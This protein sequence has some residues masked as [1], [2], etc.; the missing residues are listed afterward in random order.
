MQVLLKFPAE[1]VSNLSA[2][3]YLPLVTRLANETS[4]KART[5]AAATLKLLHKQLQ[6]P[7]ND[8]LAGYS[9]QW[10]VSNSSQ[11]Q[12]LLRVAA[13][14][15]LGLL[16]E[17][18]GARF[19]QRRLTS[20][21]V[22]QLVDLLTAAAAEAEDALAAMVL[23]DQQQQQQGLPEDAN[24]A[25]FSSNGGVPRWQEVYHILLMLEKAIQGSAAA[26]TWQ[27][28]PA[29]Q[30][31]WHTLV[32]QLLLHP[33]LWVRKVAGRLLGLALATPAIHEGFICSSNEG[34]TA[35]DGSRAAASSE[36]SVSAGAAALLVY[37]Q[38]E[39]D[40]V[41]EG[42]CTQ[43]IKCL[44]ALARSLAAQQTQH[45]QHLST[46]VAS[47]AANGNHAGGSSDSD[48]GAA[49]DGDGSSDGEPDAEDNEQQQNGDSAAA[50]DEEAQRH[51]KAEV[52]LQGLIV[53]MVKMAEDTRYARQLQRLAALRW[54]AAVAAAVGTQPLLPHLTLLLRPL[55]RIA[56]ATGSSKIQ[57]QAVQ[58]AEAGAAAGGTSEEV[59]VLSEQVLAHLRTLFGSE[60]LLAAYTAAREAVRA[61][62]AAR[63]TAAA[64]RVLL[65]PEAASRMKIKKG[66]KKSETR[67]RKAEERR[68]Q[69]SSRASG[70]FG[71]KAKAGGRVK[72]QADGGKMKG[73][74]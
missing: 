7:Q 40:V 63:K 58:G 53:R 55:Y 47:A 5:A 44:V 18:E 34:P 12:Q 19:G 70:G 38:L 33:H 69:R 11:Q 48:E 45:Q 35:G 23:G 16:A 8:Q 52:T 1:V 21:F 24:G 64:R 66:K 32:K 42:L 6:Q 60:Q 57:H 73:K 59:R 2:T 51:K 28:G 61:A 13:A 54:I 15:A 14:H 10:L 67:Q 17:V 74:R 41:D 65:D 22:S 56:E 4:P 36:Y 20:E 30:Q 25:S 71:Y 50:A 62:R 46:G 39:A 9:Q 43:A 72:R 49:D 29:V 3:V 31:Y 68:R 27:Q 26:L 37:R